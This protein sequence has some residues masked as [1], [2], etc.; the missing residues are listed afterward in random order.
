MIFQ[1]FK[2]IAVT[3]KV[4]YPALKSFD[5]EEGISVWFEMLKD[6]EYHIT[7]K[8][9]AAYIK[10]N[11]FAP[12]VADVRRYINTISGNEWSIAWNKLKYGAKLKEVDYPG[13]YAYMTIGE[14]VFEESKDIRV[15]VEFQKLYREFCL[16]DNAVKRDLFLA[17]MLK[18]RDEDKGRLAQDDNGKSLP[19]A[20]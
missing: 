17:G 2:V 9:V 3:L 14:R 1:E 11:Q 8:A 10:E 7:S 4:A 6:L 16:M 5:T 12:S 20:E 19:L 18:C 13:Q 15:M